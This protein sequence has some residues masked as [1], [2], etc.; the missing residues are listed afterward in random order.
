MI[1]Y[2]CFYVAFYASS[3]SAFFGD[4]WFKNPFSKASPEPAPP[5]SV[6]ESDLTNALNLIADSLYEWQC[7]YQN[8]CSINS[9]FQHR[10][11]QLLYSN[12]YYGIKSFGNEFARPKYEVWIKTLKDF[13]TAN[14]NTAGYANMMEIISQILEAYDIAQKTDSGLPHLYDRMLTLLIKAYD[15]YFMDY[16]G[17]SSDA[18]SKGSPQNIYSS[19]G[20]KKYSQYGTGLI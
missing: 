7:V 14:S 15:V 18:K 17:R 10:I 3:V 1:F 12:N 9:N 8:Y 2:S 6:T 19:W 20:R 11:E 13:Q 4:G 16:P 5:S